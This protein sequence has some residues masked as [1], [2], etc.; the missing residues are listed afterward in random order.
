MMFSKKSQVTSLPAPV[1]GLNGKDALANMPPTDAWKM[2]NW[3]PEPSSVSLRNGSVTWCNNITGSVETLAAYNSATGSKLFAACGANIY[4]VTAQGNTGA[5]V[6]TGLTSAR[7]QYVNYGNPAG[8]WLIMCNGQDHVQ[9]YNGTAWA[10]STITGVAD[11]TLINVCVFKNRLFFIQKNTMS[12]WYLAVNAVGG[13]ASQFD[14]TSLFKL[15]GYLVSCT[16]WTIDTSGSGIID[17]LI[18]MSSMGEVVMY[19]GSDPSTAGSWSIAGQFRVGRPVGYRCFQKIGSDV[20]FIGADGLYPMSKALLTDRSQTQDAVTNKIVN[21]INNDVQSYGNNWGWQ[22]ILY[23]I[24]NKVIINVPQLTNQIQYQYVMNT[25]TGA[26]CRF[27]GWNANCFEIIGDNIFYGGLNKV[28]QCD[29]GQNDEGAAITAD[30]GQAFNY[31]GQS[32]VQKRFTAARPIISANAAITPSLIMNIN[33][34]DTA[35]TN[36]I[37]FSNTAFSQ[38]NTSPWNTSPWSSSNKIR[39]DWQSI[40]GIGFC[41]SPRIAISAKNA[42]VTWQST[43]I[44]YEPGGTF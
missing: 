30:T 43:D 13:A 17:Y 24:G 1:G 39:S 6:V 35:P 21:I 16:P 26:W 37:S 15:G 14:L 33:F 20:V 18:F 38:W 23:P 31:F 5:A 27:T 7:W 36:V 4:D 2:D 3:F 41:G 28:V 42:I 22:V 9:T 11:T 19:Q 29:V 8:Q 34:D 12:F 25:V 32:G 44:V 10:A 40:Y